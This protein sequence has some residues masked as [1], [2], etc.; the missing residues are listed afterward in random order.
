[1]HVC[2]QFE[3][4][5]SNQELYQL[6]CEISV[7][8]KSAFNNYHPVSFRVRKVFEIRILTG[9][10]D[11]EHEDDRGEGFEVNPEKCFH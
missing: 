1:M 7:D 11:R 9:E 8:M 2:I 3:E 10:K 6:N 4:G 5:K